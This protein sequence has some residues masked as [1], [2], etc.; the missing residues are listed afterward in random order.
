[1]SVEKFREL[2]RQEVEAALVR[3]FEENQDVDK[4]KSAVT[5]DMTEYIARTS[6][7]RECI[8]NDPSFTKYE[9]T[10]AGLIL[11]PIVV[12]NSEGLNQRFAMLEDRIK[13]RLDYIEKLVKP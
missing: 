5:K 3:Y 11:P 12:L 13:R 10:T 6:K 2:V 7:V 4:I 8:T 1:M 9:I